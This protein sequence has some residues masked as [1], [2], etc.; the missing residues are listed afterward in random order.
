NRDVTMFTRQLAGLT[1]SNVPILRALFTISEQTENRSLQKVVADLERTIRDGNMLSDALAK[2][3]KLFSD[4]YINMVRSGESGGVLDIILAR[5]SEAREAEEDLKRKVRAAMAYPI[6]IIIVGLAT[7]GVL[8]T[9]FLPQV[10]DLF[11]DYHDLPLP[12]R[13]LIAISEFAS[14]NWHWVALILM[15][16]GVTFRRLAAMETGRAFA[17]RIKLHIPLFGKFLRLTDIARFARTLAILLDSGIPI[18]RALTLSAN[19]LE[20]TILRDEIRD[21]RN[22][23][24]E[25]GVPLSFGLRKTQYFPL[26]VSN[27]AAVGEEAGRLDETLIEVASFYEKE[28]DARS[29]LTTSLLEPVL[30]LIVGAVVG[31]IV[32]AMLLPI[33]ELSSAL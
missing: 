1:K 5:L 32:A 7:V 8:L 4:L 6:L 30:I 33:F 22:A 29:A 10:I 12:T 2:Y 21:V 20:N 9:V 27:M 23:V 19:T 13:L 28:L 31:L 16:A 17:D 3:P 18:D 25:Q 15:L 24:V 11:K 14:H 26:L